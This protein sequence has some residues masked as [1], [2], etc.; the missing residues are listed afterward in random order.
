MTLG[1]AAIVSAGIVL[2]APFMGQLNAWLRRAA[3]DQF[4]AIVIASLAVLVTL[5]LVAAIRNIRERRALR[6]GAI[7]AALATAAAYSLA[8]TTG[9]RD[10]DWVERVHFVEYGLVGFLFYRAWRTAGDL[11]CLLLPVLAGLFVGL[12]EEWLQW[13]IPVRVGE[14]HDVL[15]NL[16]AVSCGLVVSVA[17][18]PPDTFAWRVH[19]SSRR[20]LAVVGSLAVFGFAFFIDQV[21]LGHLIAREG[22][23]FR[24]HYTA[25]QLA[26]LA[27]DRAERWQTNPPIVMRRLSRE[28]QYMDEGLW[29]VR[30][31]NLAEAP[32]AWAENRILEEFYAPVLDTPSYVSATGHRWSAAQRAAIL[33][34][35]PAAGGLVVSSAEPYPIYTF[36]RWWLW[37]AAG[38]LVAALGIYGLTPQ[39]TP[40]T[41]R[42]F[43]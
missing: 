1:L 30:R 22:V 7:A 43:F 2:A 37:S 4:L 12:T 41:Q 15:L 11:S 36:P 19:G 25:P 17:A 27:R 6:Y 42:Q 40:R 26:A 10:V 18:N 13:F 33:Q 20:R 3:P 14:L 8:T 28:D 23:A 21:H 16:V 5:G 35:A 29:H 9:S 24:S 31:R 39:R 32:D 38:I 34:E